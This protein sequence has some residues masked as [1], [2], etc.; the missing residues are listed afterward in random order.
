MAKSKSKVPSSNYFLKLSTACFFL[1]LGLCGILPNIEESIFSLNNNNLVV[2]AIFGVLE[3]ICA[4]VI[5][6][7]LFTQVKKSWM[8]F[9]SLIIFIFWI[10]TIVFTQFFNKF[11]ISNSGIAFSPDI[12]Q[13]ILNLLLEL[14]VLAAIWSI[15]RH[16]NE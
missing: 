12:M 16:Y 10:I 5:F 1:V 4:L 9:A 15:N 14:V 13:W 3:I 8:A 11:A 7:G 6:A 2:E